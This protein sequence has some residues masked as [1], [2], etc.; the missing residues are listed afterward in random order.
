MAL[1]KD[2]AIV[3][4]RLDYS[5]T[6]QVLLMLCRSHGAQRMIAKGVKRGTRQKASVG[7]DLLELGQVAF[8]RRDGSAAQLATMTEWRQIARHDAARRDLVEWYAVQYAAEI[9]ALLL[10]ESDP[11][12]G[13]FEALLRCLDCE[14]VPGVPD[15]TIARLAVYQAALLRA[16]GL[17]PQFQA[18]VGCGGS[19]GD[20]AECYFSSRQGGL[21]CRD[22]EPAAVEKRRIQAS[23]VHV[24]SRLS[25][26]SSLLDSGCSIVPGNSSAESTLE[27]AHSN[28][29]AWLGA[30]DLCDYHIT[31]TV[32]RPPRL[33]QP[34]RDALRGSG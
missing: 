11:H 17:L 19:A 10:E 9:T 4:R 31:E 28:Q 12:P 1:Y 29:A 22:C 13:L 34:L 5:E 16:T 21:L 6:S 20:S 32:S 8:S 7:I 24:L 30:F 14:S 25:S 33:S 18:C 23:T 26:G 3:L 15:L 2:D 27:P